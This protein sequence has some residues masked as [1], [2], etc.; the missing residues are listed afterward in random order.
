MDTCFISVILLAR[1][2]SLLS[3]RL[4]I[5]RD[6]IRLKLIIFEYDLLKPNLYLDVSVMG[7]MFSLMLEGRTKVIAFA[8]QSWLSKLYHIGNGVCSNT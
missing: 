2:S 7:S 5:F 6:C 4:N 8:S 3:V 1:P